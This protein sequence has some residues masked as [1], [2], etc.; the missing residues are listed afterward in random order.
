MTKP[1]RW[2][3]FVALLAFTGV[4][5]VLAFVLALTNE[6]PGFYERQFV[7][8]F[9]LNIAVASLLGAVVLLA[10]VR[11]AVRKRQRK[12][13]SLLL[14]RLAGIFALVVCCRAR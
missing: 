10:A 4:L 1:A 12:F 2:G 5:L 9:W 6:G 14:I 3:W 8:L 13:G 11:L 7:W